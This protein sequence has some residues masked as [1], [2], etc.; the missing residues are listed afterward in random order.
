MLFI[1]IICVVNL[2]VLCGSYTIA[3]DRLYDNIYDNYEDIN[4]KKHIKNYNID[5]YMNNRLFNEVSLR[6]NDKKVDTAKDDV[7]ANRIVRKFRR[8]WKKTTPAATKTVNSNKNDPFAFK[9]FDKKF[10]E[11]L[12]KVE[13]C[14]FMK[15]KDLNKYEEGTTQTYEK[16]TKHKRKKNKKFKFNF[17]NLRKRDDGTNLTVTT[18]KP[19]NNTGINKRNEL[20]NQ[21]ENILSAVELEEILNEIKSRALNAIGNNT[22][23]KKNKLEKRHA[24]KD[25]TDIIREEISKAKCNLSKDARTI[26]KKLKEIYKYIKCNTPLQ[27]FE[28]KIHLRN[29]HNGGQVTTQVFN[30]K[31]S[32]LVVTDDKFVGNNEKEVSSATISTE[33]ANISTE[34]VNFNNNSSLTSFEDY[35]NGYRYY[36]NFQKAQDD[37]LFSNH[38]KYQAH[39]HHNV[40]DIG[41]CF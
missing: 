34:G 4:N 6:H 33:E 2:M 1:K 10:K 8:F 22:E 9:H 13:R 19:N 27:D 39:K 20:S 12:S 25:T 24:N 38:V 35:V 37:S 28:K 32:N 14:T 3:Q 40:D 7:K 15:L 5:K 11:K 30:D 18:K 41:K 21:I 23:V 31:I 16:N 29:I 36:L 17:H 26:R